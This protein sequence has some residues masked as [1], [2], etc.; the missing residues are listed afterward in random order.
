MGFIGVKIS[1]EAEQALRNRATRKG[2]LSKIVD[3]AL[4]QYFKLEEKNNE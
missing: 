1:N 4:K 2:D 3:K